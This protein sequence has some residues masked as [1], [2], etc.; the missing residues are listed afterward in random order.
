M[1]L[2]EIILVATL[3]QMHT[4]VPGYGF[5]EL[6]DLITRLNPAALLVELQQSEVSDFPKSVRGSKVEYNEAI[7]PLAI[8]LKIPTIPLEPSGKERDEILKVYEA[9]WKNAESNPNYAAFS[10]YTDLLISQLLKYWKNSL[11]VNSD[12]TVESFRLKHAYQQE[13]L[14]VDTPS[15]EQWNEC[16]LRSILSA[17]E[18]HKGKRLVVTVGAEHVYWLKDRLLKQNKIQLV[19]VSDAL[20]N[21]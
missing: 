9:A 17:A 6:S 8:K 20:S 21:R 15:W 11:D 3:H 5:N 13:L 12:V 18:T 7:M 4:Q 10:K 2:T 16:F 14:S 19:S 1:G